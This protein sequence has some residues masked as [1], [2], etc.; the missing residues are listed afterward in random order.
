MKSIQRKDIWPVLIVVIG[1]AAVVMLT[2]VIDE[3]RPETQKQF[4]EKSLY[5]S[6]NTAKRLSLSF[7]GLAADFYWMR[8]L[9]YVGRK[10]VSYEDSHEGN[11]YLG[12]LSGLEL[13]LLPQLLRISTTLDPQFLAP[14]EYGAVILPEI[15]SDEAIDLLNRGIAA[16]PT[17]WR[18]YQ[19]LAYIYWKRDDYQKA[20]EIYAAGGR[21]PGAPPWMTA[22]SARMNADGGSRNAARE[23]YRHLGEASNDQAVKDM[24]AKQIMRLDSL[25]E[26]DS[27]RRA[28]K[29]YLATNNRCISN[30]R[31]LSPA[32]RASGMRLDESTGAPLDPSGMA[33]RLIKTGC[34]VDL[35]GNSIIQ[36]R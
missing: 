2:R 21:Q 12:N 16:N 20:G 25:D 22:M 32:L 6:A 8:T 5:V 10:I 36:K 34:D 31:E 1:L 15:N 28:L 24:V 4:G 3:R 19:H 7:N 18:L 9:Q 17:A 11:F 33:Y 30:W 35:D 27:I 26:R 29:Q 13:H 23:I 14:Y